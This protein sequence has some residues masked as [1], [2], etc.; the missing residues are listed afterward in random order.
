M[1]AAL[2]RSLP[3]PVPVKAVLVILLLALVVYACF[4]WVFPWVG[5]RLPYADTTVG[6]AYSVTT[7]HSGRLT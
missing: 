7:A 2:W 1:Y 3:G 5:E 4:T 6:A